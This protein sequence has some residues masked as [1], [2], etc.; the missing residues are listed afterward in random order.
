MV[1]ELTGKENKLCI[2][3][4]LM[5]NNKILD[6]YWALQYTVTSLIKQLHGIVFFLSF[7]T[8]TKNIVL[9]VTAMLLVHS[10]IFFIMIFLAPKEVVGNNESRRGMLKGME[11]KMATYQASL[12]IRNFRSFNRAI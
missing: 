10:L 1:T 4:N 12:N 6:N 8:T 9:T 2:Y 11:I 3:I 7:Q 5:P